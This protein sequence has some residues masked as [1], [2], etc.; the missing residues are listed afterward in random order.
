[1]IY[2]EVVEDLGDGDTVTRRFS[3]VDIANAYIGKYR[4]WC[5]HESNPR[6]VDTESPNFFHDTMLT[7]DE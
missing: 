1:M 7:D 3:N 4:E 2:Y 5:Y 6:R